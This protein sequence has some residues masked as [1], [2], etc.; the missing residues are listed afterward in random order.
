MPDG[1]RHRL[2][3]FLGVWLAALVA[4]YQQAMKT[5]FTKDALR[6]VQQRAA[7]AVKLL[8]DTAVERLS[9]THRSFAIQSA[10]SPRR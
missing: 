9:F 1:D 6:N 4:D 2:H 5:T 3:D 7:E 8:L 10:P